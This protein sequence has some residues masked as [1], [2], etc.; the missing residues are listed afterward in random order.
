MLDCGFNLLIYGVG[1]KLDII[2]IFVQREIQ[3]NQSVL[4]FNGYHTACNMKC[5]VYS[6]VDWLYKERY[7]GFGSEK[8]QFFPRNVSMHEQVLNIK[9]EFIR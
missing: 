7:K 6:I 4:V 1:S 3:S 8:K 9:R 5:I 2:N